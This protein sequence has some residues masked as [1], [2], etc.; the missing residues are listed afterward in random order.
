MPRFVIG[1]HLDAQPE[2]ISAQDLDEALDEAITIARDRNY[3]RDGM[4]WAVPV[5]VGGA[6]FCPLMPTQQKDGP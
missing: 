3:D 1:T 5:S 4:A 6:E 2:T